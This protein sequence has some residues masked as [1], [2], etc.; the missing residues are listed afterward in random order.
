MKHETQVNLI[1]QI[2]DAIDRGTPPIAERFT[3]N[4]TSAYTSSERAARERDVLFRH[5]PIV[6]GFSS[7]IPNPGDYLTEDLAPVPILIARNTTLDAR[8]VVNICRHRGAQLEMGCAH[9]ANLFPCP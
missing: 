8:A 3:R 5:H 9:T 4:D 6:A 1:H 2:F 7:Q